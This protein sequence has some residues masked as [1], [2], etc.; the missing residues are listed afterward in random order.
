MSEIVQYRSRVVSGDLVGTDNIVEWLRTMMRDV[1]GSIY[2][3]RSEMAIAP[4]LCSEEEAITLHD[5]VI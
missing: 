1:V 5:V 3:M 4:G 2:P